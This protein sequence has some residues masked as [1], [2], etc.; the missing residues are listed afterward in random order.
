MLQS[1]GFQR[2]GHNCLSELRTPEKLEFHRSGIRY[3]LGSYKDTE[4]NDESTCKSGHNL[5]RFSIFIFSTGF[6]VTRGMLSNCFAIA[7][8]S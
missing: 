6:S 3:S 2:V 5:W 8:F 7:S 4:A 1:M